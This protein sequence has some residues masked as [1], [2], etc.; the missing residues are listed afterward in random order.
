[1]ADGKGKSP[2]YDADYDAVQCAVRNG[3]TC[4][5]CGNRIAFIGKRGEKGAWNKPCQGSVKPDPTGTGRRRSSYGGK[6]IS[7][8]SLV[9][10]ET[11]EE[12]LRP[13]TPEPESELKAPTSAATPA[14]QNVDTRQAN[15]D[16]T[17]TSDTTLSL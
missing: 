3:L 13:L 12:D 10:P 14:P 2:R 5:A 17:N 9:T 15:A 6:H 16:V 11:E 8:S 1:M 7:A 4:K